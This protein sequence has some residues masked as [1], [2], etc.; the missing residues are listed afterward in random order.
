MRRAY[1]KE[2]WPILY[3]ELI[4]TEK[5][6][7]HLEEIDIYCRERLETIE[8]AMM[9]Q[10]GVMEAL[11]AADQMAWVRSMSSIHNPYPPGH[12]SHSHIQLTVRT[13]HECGKCQ[14]RPSVSRV[15]K[16]WALPPPS[17][18]GTGRWMGETV[19]VQDEQKGI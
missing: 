9:Q 5:L 11:K 10:E 4:V 7:Y 14:Y 13:L 12:N 19:P 17:S 15:P 3:S 1:L 18:A 6:Y 16:N 2:H 8:K